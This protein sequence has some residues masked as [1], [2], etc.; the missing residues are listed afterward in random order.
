MSSRRHGSPRRANEA[1]RSDPP[2][3]SIGEPDGPAV[4]RAPIVV[5]IGGSLL[6]WDELPARLNAFLNEHAKQKLVFVVGGGRVVDEIR[7]LDQIHVLGEER[8]HALA[9]RALDVTAAILADLVPG[10]VVL[11]QVE[12]FGTVWSAGGAP[13]LAPRKFLDSDDSSPDA[14]PHAWTVTSDSIAARVAD[15]LRASDLILLKS[16]PAPENATMNEVA[17]LGLVDAFFPVACHNLTQVS[18]INLC[19]DGRRVILLGA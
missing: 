19:G 17:R 11:D 10:L 16:A 5:K 7:R 3:S 9:I 1:S 12:K 18:Y 2:T 13:V 14:L 15:R 4:E 6:I 8:A